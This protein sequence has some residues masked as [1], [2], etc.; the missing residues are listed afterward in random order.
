[1]HGIMLWRNRWLAF[2]HDLV[3]IPVVLWLAFWLRFNLGEIPGVY[4]ESLLQLLFIA[5]P[6]QAAIFWVFG[7]YRGIWRYA[8]IPDLFRILK[9]VMIGTLI[10]FAIEFILYRMDNMPRSVLILYPLLLAMALAVPRMLYRWIKDRR[11][12]M[13]QT[14]ALPALVVGAGRA[15]EMLVRDLLKSGQYLSVGFLDD[16]LKKQGLDI[17]GVRVLG[18][19]DNLEAIVEKFGVEVVLLAIPSASR[20]VIKDFYER[21]RKLDVQCRTLPSVEE[22]AGGKVEVSLLRNVQIEDLLGR[23]QVELDEAAIHGLIT[24][25]RVL[26]TGAG[27]SI[28]SELCRQVLAQGP[29]QL[30]MLDHG[31]FNLYQIDQELGEPGRHVTPVLG[32]VRDEHRM[33]WL[34]ETFK[35]EVVFHAAA[36]KHVPL[37]EDNPAEGVRTNVFG[38]RLLAD[39]AVEFGVERFILV[40][41]DKAVNPTNVMGASKRTAEVY[42]QNLNARSES[43]RFITT[44]FGNVLGSAGSVVPLFRSQITAGGPVTVTHPDITR[45]FMTIP[46]AVSLILQAGAMGEGGEIFVLDMGEPVKIVHLAEQMIRL[47]GF[48]PYEDIGIEFI[49]LR[50]GEKLYEELFHESEALSATAHPKLLLSNARHVEWKPMLKALSELREACEVRDVAVLRSRLKVLVPEYGEAAHDTTLQPGA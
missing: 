40:S 24:G 15:G 3:W 35:P 26:V 31:E 39:L 11:L 50:P 45:Y 8:S 10:C 38:T 7:L 9:A 44:R 49:G 43:T 2:L 32:N 23:E 21:C 48:E 20:S 28:G 37:V 1:M 47:S 13:L 29:S 5:L 14:G 46:E 25:K 27:G 6:I 12:I 16:D 34:F 4:Q 33:R 42:C 41:T 17:H 18:G 22:L 36:Y 19:S 30:I